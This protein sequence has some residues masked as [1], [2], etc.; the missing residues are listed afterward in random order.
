MDQVSRC[1]WAD[2]SE[3][4][5]DY[6]DNVWGR[7]VKDDQKLFRMLS[8]E[9]FQAGLSWETILNKAESFDLAFDN[10]DIEKV[11][12]Y[13]QIKI[14]QLMED[15]SIVRNRMKIE[16]TINNAKVILKIQD[17][18][19][20]FSDYIWK[21]VIDT[22]VISP[23]SESEEI[24]ASNFLSDHISKDMKKDGFKF[25]GTTIIYSFLQAVGVLNDHL[26]S[27]DFK[28]VD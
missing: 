25:I 15:K 12:Q 5:R 26:T 28:Y 10:F 13:D 17:K 8:L 11:S 9:L 22:P 1:P 14:D 3:K 7:P 18:H 21:Y 24:P 20:S 27:C 4:M 16:A 6:H 23:W 2:S 19:R